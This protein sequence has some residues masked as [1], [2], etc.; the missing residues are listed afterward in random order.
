MSEIWKPVVGF[1]GRYEVSDL[2]RVKS[3]ARVEIYQRVDQYSD[4]KN[5]LTVERRCK[6][7]ILRPGA[8]ASGHVSVA[9]GH[10]AKSYDVHILVLTAF[11]S[12][13]PKGHECCHDNDVPNDNRLENL[14]WGTRSKNL[15]DAVRN[16][17]KPIGSDNWNAKL[18][19]S[20]VAAIR[21]RIGNRPLVGVGK[22]DTSL[23]SMRAVGA[24]FGVS[25][26]VVRAIIRGHTW[27][28]FP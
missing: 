12:P 11:V 22:H 3:L 23:E 16:G 9:L 5:I 25:G 18:T 24:D 2:G 10:P 8:R 14:G 27:K 28:N 15:S 26:D 6:E 13:C 21:N 20:D 17:K 19:A 1:E 4:N 7:R